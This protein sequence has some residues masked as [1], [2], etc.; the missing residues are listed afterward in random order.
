MTS[1][2]TSSEYVTGSTIAGSARRFVR[3]I[4]AS[5]GT[6]AATARRALASTARAARTWLPRLIRNLP[7]LGGLMGLRGAGHADGVILGSASRQVKAGP[8]QASRAAAVRRARGGR[9]PCESMAVASRS[10]RAGPGREIAASTS[11]PRRQ[12]MQIGAFIFPTEYSIRIDE[13]ARALEERGLESLVR[14]RAHAHPRQPPH[15][16]ARRRPA[17]EGV[18]AHAGPLRRARGG[19]R[20]DASGSSSAPGSAW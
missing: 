5:P 12:G 14:D 7:D 20:R 1:P 8:R 16:L 10:P 2:A 15:P 13:L 17:S 6:G 11:A 19:G 4:F 3:S 9:Q 18:R